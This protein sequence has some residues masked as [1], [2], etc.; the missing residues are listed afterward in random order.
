MSNSPLVLLSTIKGT[1]VNSKNK[2]KAKVWIESAKLPAYGFVRH[3][4][5]RVVYTPSGMSIHLDPEGDRVVSGRVRNGKALSIFDLSMPVE[6]RDSMFNNAPK[7]AV[8]VGYGLI[9]IQAAK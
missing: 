1:A 9:T 4:A 6:Q 2:A 3:A 7:L 5:Y 8:H